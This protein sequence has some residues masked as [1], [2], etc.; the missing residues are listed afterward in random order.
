MSKAVPLIVIVDDEQSVCRALKRLICSAGL[1][2]E[3][4]TSGAEFFEF[5]KLKSPDCLVLDLHMPVMSGFDV[6]ARLAQSGS[7]LPVITITGH[8]TPEVQ[9]RVLAAGAAAY[10]RKPVSD[11]ILLDAIKTAIG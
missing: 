5:L 11:K 2:A 9:Q 3:A 10:L 6:Q 8:D 4:F 1:E 7:A